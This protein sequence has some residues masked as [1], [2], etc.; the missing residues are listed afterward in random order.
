MINQNGGGFLSGI[1]VVTKNLII[2]NVLMW[3][4]SLV[5][6]RVGIDLTSW[7][8]LHFPGAKDFYAFQFI[9]YMFMHDTHSFAHVFFNMFAVYMFGRVL[10][11]VWGPKRFLIFYMVTGIGAG[12]VQELTW[13][14]DLRDVM[15]APQ[16][17]INIGGGQILEKADFYNL[18]VTVGASGAVFGIL[19]AFGMLF[20]NVPLYLMFVP[21][22]IKAKYFVIFYGLAE[23]TLGVANFSGDSVAHFAHLGGMLFGFFMIQYW[24][25]KG[26]NNGFYF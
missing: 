18:F 4:A 9:T 1:P 7:L 23:L 8:G 16:E 20:P 5:L 24:R 6:P 26:V 2:I 11:Q 15:A 17:L 19:L 12:L 21:I 22:P 25:K 3:V 13:M 14:Y 10:E